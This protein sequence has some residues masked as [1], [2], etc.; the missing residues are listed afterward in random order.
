MHHRYYAPVQGRFLSVD[1]TQAVQRNLHQ[2]QDWNPYAH[3][4]NNPML[5]VD[6]DGRKGTIVFISQFGRET[7]P[8]LER[9]LN[10]AV[11]G[12]RFEGHVSGLERLRAR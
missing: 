8:N 11:R 12:T 10:Q 2:P 4:M 3:T 7:T 6:P 5:R 9:Q 1:P